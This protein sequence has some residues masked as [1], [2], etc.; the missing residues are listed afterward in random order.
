VLNL[1]DKYQAD[2]KAVRERQLDL[3][4]ANRLSRFEVWLNCSNHKI[5]N[6]YTLGAL[7]KIKVFS[8]SIGPGLDDIESEITYL[9]IREV[10]PETVV[11]IAPYCGWSTSWILNALR[12]NKYGQLYSYDLV[13]Y[14]TKVLPNELTQGIWCFIQGDVTRNVDLLP[15]KIDYLFID[16]DHSAEFAHW[17]IDH[18]FPKL[19]GG[20]PV[21]VHDIFAESQ[22]TGEALVVTEWLARN[23]IDFFSA[24]QEKHKESYDR[25]RSKKKQAGIDK[26]IHF[27][28]RNP[29]IFF[30]AP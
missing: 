30:R 12:D 26:Q 20:I 6:Y 22:M 1:Y 24:S 25:I 3:Y 9:L 29:M 8:L 27:A 13:D 21:S 16:A 4:P 7:R 14:S 2:L 28:D 23:E 15:P 5:L 11:E 10:R 17:Y 18:V 19:E